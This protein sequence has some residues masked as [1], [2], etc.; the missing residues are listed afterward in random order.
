MRLAID[1]KGTAPM[2]ATK[3]LSDRKLAANRAN[4]QRS[5]GPR[6]P[7]GKAKVSLNAVTH[8]LRSEMVVLPTEDPIEFEAMRQGFFDDWKPQTETRRVLVERA[9]AGAWRLRR[10]VKIEHDRLTDQIN[11]AVADYDARAKARVTEGV[12]LFKVHPER[13]LAMLRTEYDG[14]VGLAKLWTTLGKVAADWRALTDPTMHHIRLLNL[15]GHAGSA[16]AGAVGAIAMASWR[17]LI[18]NAPDLGECDEFVAD[19]EK[20]E[21]LASE[22]KA[23]ALAMAAAYR[24][25]LEQFSDPSLVRAK[26]ADMASFDVSR[27][28]VA[29]QRYEGQLDRSFRAN[30]N[31]LIKLA[32]TGADLIEAETIE[33]NKPTEPDSIAPNK[34]TEPDRA[35]PHKPTEGPVPTVEEP[36]APNKPTEVGAVGEDRALH[37]AMLEADRT[38]L[39]R[40]Y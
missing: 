10:C 14:I 35:A 38:F 5:T 16:D 36:D 20:A 9:A 28:G 30:L 22:I 19:D 11:Q 24:A 6:T 12:R 25:E 21:R 8:G 40:G 31:Q 2:T 7:E 32:Q 18:W 1:T 3:L 34:P 37:E 15:L 17:L 23:Y 13:G 33:P 4:A 39:M 29:L 27:E 26:V